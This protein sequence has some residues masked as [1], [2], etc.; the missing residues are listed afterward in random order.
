MLIPYKT[1][2]SDSNYLHFTPY[3]EGSENIVKNEIPEISDH[4]QYENCNEFEPKLETPQ[5]SFTNIYFCSESS[6]PHFLC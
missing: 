5:E 6:G 3:Q 2:Y 4:F 1:E